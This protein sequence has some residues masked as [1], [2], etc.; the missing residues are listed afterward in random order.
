M[1][2]FTDL[3]KRADPDAQTPDAALRARLAVDGVAVELH[4]VRDWRLR[5]GIPPEYW[6][7]LSRTGLVSLEELAAAAA[8]KKLPSSSEAA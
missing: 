5:N 3:I 6:G 4:Q 2:T 7:A 8:A 1:L